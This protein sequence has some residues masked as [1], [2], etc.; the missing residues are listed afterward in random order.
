MFSRL[1]DDSGFVV[2]VGST[3]CRVALNA[4][5]RHNLAGNRTGT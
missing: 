3:L 2:A 5:E 1:D 4:T